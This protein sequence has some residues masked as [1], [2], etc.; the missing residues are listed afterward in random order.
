MPR[1]DR[2]CDVTPQEATPEQAALR[3][4]EEAGMTLEDA[5]AFFEAL[6][7]MM[8]TFGLS[9]VEAGRTAAFLASRPRGG[10]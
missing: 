5:Q 1:M 2:F 7:R 6:A 8:R 4:L 9:L 10:A 3:L